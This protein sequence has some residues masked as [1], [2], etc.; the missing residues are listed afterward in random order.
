MPIRY[1]EFIENHNGGT[2]SLQVFKSENNERVINCFL[3]LSAPNSFQFSIKHHLSG[4]KDRYPKDM[5]P[6]ASA[7]GGDMILI[8]IC[9]H[10]EGKLFYWDHDF[11]SDESGVDYYDNIELIADDLDMFLKSLYEPNA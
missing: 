5:F 7:G 2:P 1:I 6:I 4:Y 8:G 11:E 9:E 3:A 10:N